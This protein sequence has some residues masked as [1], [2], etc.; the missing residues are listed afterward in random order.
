MKALWSGDDD[1]NQCG[2]LS[3]GSGVQEVVLPGTLRQISPDM[4]KGCDSLRV[5]R[6]ARGYP[7]D[8]R[9]FVDSRVKV[10]RK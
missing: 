10:R 3:K 4:F 7:L 6:V 8:V 2:W 1:F 9:K 5:V